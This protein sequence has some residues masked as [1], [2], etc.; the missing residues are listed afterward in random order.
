VF[1]WILYKGRGRCGEICFP[2]FW[3]ILLTSIRDRVPFEIFMVEA[4]HGDH[5]KSSTLPIWVRLL[6]ATVH[7]EDLCQ[8]AGSHGADGCM[9]TKISIP[10]LRF[11]WVLGFMPAK[12]SIP[13]LRLYW[14]LGFMPTKILE[15]C[16]T[17]L[18]PSFDTFFFLR[19]STQVLVFGISDLSHSFDLDLCFN[20][21]F[22]W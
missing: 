18:L 16:F 19:N 10:R 5:P 14:V 12:T 17:L 13:K 1:L 3:P 15:I 11:Y 6:C 8:K 21:F 2:W 9:P 22:F 4:L 20:T 7:S